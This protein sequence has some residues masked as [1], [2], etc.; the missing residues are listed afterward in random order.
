MDVSFDEFKRISRDQWV[1]K[2]DTDLKG[3]K[4]SSDF[5]YLVESGLSIDPFLTDACVE[6]KA[7]IDGPTSRAGV[8]IDI[9]DSHEANLESLA[10]LRNGAESL[11]IEIDNQTNFD[12][13]FDG[14]YVDMIDVVL[15]YAGEFLEKEIEFIAYLHR[16][17][18]KIP[19]GISIQSAS[20]SK[21]FSNIVVALDHSE[22]FINRLSSMTQVLMGQVKN[23]RSKGLVLKLSL[24]QD[25]FAQIAELRAIRILWAKILEVNDQ[26]FWP[27]QVISNIDLSSQNVKEKHPLIAVNY[28][29]ISAYFGMSD[30][31]FG[32]PISGDVELARLS[33]NIQ[34]IFKE[35]SLLTQVIDPTAGSYVIEKLTDEMVK[36]V[37]DKVS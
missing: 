9:L 17:Y 5:S 31:V 20:W 29:M 4:L 13:L 16:R 24:K 15:I 37:W 28:L 19:E 12:V 1:E 25:F 26:Q 27:L 8:Y 21:N 32:C 10:M 7:A 6:K 34:H 30:I 3:S 2:I 23:G 18:E 14:I 22:T 36:Q 33:L 11:A 35:E